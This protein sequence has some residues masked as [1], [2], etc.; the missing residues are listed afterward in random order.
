MFNQKREVAISK[1]LAL[2]FVLALSFNATACNIDFSIELQTFGENVNVELR[3]G[4]P[5]RSRAVAS[6]RSQ[7]G[8]VSFDKLCSGSYFLAIGN[9]D[10]VSVTPV[11]QFES[12][13]RYTSKITV[14]RGSGNVSKK[15]RKSL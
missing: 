8:R 15:S 11:R 12:D 5:G 14:Q 6:H 9:D 1:F 4:A 2:I 13:Y 10:S 3:S 7:G